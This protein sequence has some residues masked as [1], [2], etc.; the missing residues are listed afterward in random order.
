MPFYHFSLE[1]PLVVSVVQNL[2]WQNALFNFVMVNCSSPFLDGVMVLTRLQKILPAQIFHIFKLIFF[3]IV[4]VLFCLAHYFHSNFLNITPIRESVGSISQFS[5]SVS[6]A[7]DGLEFIRCVGRVKPKISEVWNFGN[8][9]ITPK[10]HP[11]AHVDIGT[12][13]R[14]C[15]KTN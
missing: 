8:N 12:L 5:N 4:A 13:V 10:V 2:K 1:I 6:G 14:D 11:F 3:N 7:N 9:R 15:F